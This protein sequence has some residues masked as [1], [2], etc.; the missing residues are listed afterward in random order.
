MLKI[1]VPGLLEGWSFIEPPC[2]QEVCLHDTGSAGPMPL[3]WA[4]SEGDVFCD[5]QKSV[6]GMFGVSVSLGLQLL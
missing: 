5:S 3:P 2:W 6:A 1:K 4:G